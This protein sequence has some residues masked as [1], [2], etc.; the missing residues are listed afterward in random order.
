MEPAAITHSEV[1]KVVLHS[2]K[3]RYWCGQSLCYWFYPRGHSLRYSGS[4]CK[5][6]QE[7]LTT[8]AATYPFF[9]Q[10]ADRRNSFY[11][12]FEKLFYMWQS[13]K[14]RAEI[15]YSPMIKEPLQPAQYVELLEFQGMV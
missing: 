14:S 10:E 8:L 3:R 6:L 1:L 4:E 9:R 13:E 11:I 12:D 7:I 5:R 2:G 15:G